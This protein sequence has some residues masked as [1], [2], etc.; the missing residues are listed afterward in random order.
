[1]T[2][3]TLKFTVSLL[4]GI[5]FFSCKKV[6]FVPDQ[7]VIVDPTGGGSETHDNGFPTNYDVVFNNSKVHRIEIVFTPEEWTAMQADLKVKTAGGGGPGGTLNTEN[8]TYFPADI[9]YNDLVWKDV[10]VRYKGNSSLRANSG[11]LPLRFNFDEFE[12]VN[13]EI[14]DQRFYGFKELSMS[15]NYNDP[16]VMREHVADELFRDFGVPAIRT[17]YYEVYINN[18][19]GPEY[20]GVYTMCEIISDTFLKSYFGTKTGNCYKPDGTGAAFAQ[21]G[22]NLNHFELKTNEAQNNK[23]DV[24]KMF[25]YLHANT[26]INNPA[27]W[28][29]DLESIFDV[30]G[31]LKYLAVNTTIQN[32]DTY[33]RM[34][35]N[36]YLY[37]D[38]TMGKLR[39]IV[40][41][42]NEAFQS[43]KMGGALPFDMSGVGTNWPL[44]SY[45]IAD[46]DYLKRYK[47]YIKSFVE[48]TYTSSRMTSIF[49]SNVSLLQSSVNAERTGFSYVNGQFNSAVSTLKT[50]NSSRVSAANLFVQ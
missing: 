20:Y 14:T 6:I 46:A 45:I 38:P 29:S 18:G 48:T 27:Q 7:E 25:E 10:G 8:P 34:T 35:H 39:W 13:P 2:A 44:I 47:T 32:W 5:S 50:H 3:K 1:M 42:N 4:L 9:Y 41:D 17:V 31:F 36:Y 43:G 15:S 21:A 16:S 24:Q 22:F 40:W 37:N 49:D 30:D 23:S 11:K 19:S 12:D 33:G 28:K 26:R